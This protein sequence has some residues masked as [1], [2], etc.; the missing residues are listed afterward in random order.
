MLKSKK[1]LVTGSAKRLGEKIVRYLIG[2]S[3]RVAL[4]YNESFEQAST[5]QTELGVEIYSCDFS[6]PKNINSIAAQMGQVDIL[7]NN[8]A[9]FENDNPSTLTVENMHKHININ[10]IAPMMLVQ[11]LQGLQNVINIVDSRVIKNPTNFTSY[12]LSKMLLEYYSKI[13]AKH[14][15]PNIIINNIALGFIIKREGQA[16]KNYLESIAELPIKKEISAEDLYMALSLLLN[17]TTITGETINIDSGL[18]L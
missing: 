11:K 2:N 1:V 6:D 9:I 17:T 5:L 13:A 14:F 12:T 16:V 4:H 7:I 3:Y 10:A 15:A 18:H 8:A